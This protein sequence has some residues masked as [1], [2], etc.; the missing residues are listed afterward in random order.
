MLNL[1]VAAFLVLAGYLAGIL[2]GLTGTPVMLLGGLALLWFPGALAAGVLRLDP[3]RRGVTA[4]AWS[5]LITGLLL[6]LGLVLDLDIEG[7]VRTM[8]FAT[9]AG[10]L[11]LPRRA[12][13]EDDAI[14]PEGAG[15]GLVKSVCSRS[16][17][18]RLTSKLKPL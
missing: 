5:P 15:P 17:S 1:R 9:G 13:P 10:V 11:L 6:T 4:A 12:A 3:V 16:T 2:N 14:E 7:T 8:V 18:E